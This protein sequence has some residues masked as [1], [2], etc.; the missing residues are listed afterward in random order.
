VTGAQTNSLASLLRYLRG[1]RAPLTL[2][3]TLS[4]AACGSVTSPVSP[5]AAH[6]TDTVVAPDAPLDA[7]PVSADAPD[8]LPD[9]LLTTALTMRAV[10]STSATSA[11]EPLAAMSGAV[12]STRAPGLRASRPCSRSR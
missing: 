5:D 2:S 10:R 4:L 3:L 12:T 1:V 11:A 9:A 6:P 8:A 7:R